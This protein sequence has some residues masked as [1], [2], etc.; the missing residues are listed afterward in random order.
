MEKTIV[1]QDDIKKSDFMEQ[2]K[3]KKIKRSHYENKEEAKKGSKM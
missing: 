1:W 3:E 2:L